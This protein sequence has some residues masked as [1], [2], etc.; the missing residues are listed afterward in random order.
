MP[1][2]TAT[3][4]PTI[5]ITELAAGAPDAPVLVVGPALGTTAPTIW[6]AAAGLLGD[7]FRV[8]GWDLPGH[9]AGVPAT[10][11]SIAELAAGVRAGVDRAAGAA[12]VF[13]YAGVSVSGVVGQQLLLDAPQ[14]LHSAVLLC[15]GARIGDRAGWQERAAGI[16]DTGTAVMVDALPERW[17][18]PEFMAAQP[19][20]VKQIGADVAAADDASYAALCEA[21]GEFDAR[22]RLAEITIPVLC[23]AGE[24]DPGTTVPMLRH[25][26]DGVVN[27]RL[28][29]LPGVSHL[30]PAQ[31][32]EDVARLI[33]EHTVTV[34]PASQTAVEA[35]A[36]GM[37][38]RREVLGDEYVN[39]VVPSA[40]GAVI[41]DLIARHAW[42]DVWARPGLDRKTRSVISIVALVSRGH[43]EELA[44]HLQGARNNGWTDE[45][46]A[47]VLLQCAIY[48]GVPEAN[49]AFRVARKA[50]DWA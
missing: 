13:H 48:C 24:L 8:L 18:T 43:H 4:T 2:S 42:N 27:G 21:L 16:R 9:G 3:A 20:L 47:E 31:A 29:V 11:F 38:I 15:T 6:G 44:L 49:S 12:T 45:E 5:A 41:Q 23:I 7:R 17:F 28:A 26:A 46:I 30:A 25:I 1:Q 35:H 22:A 19:D 33:A 14:R 37:R 50:L 40:A 34:P 32:P 36:I 39:G 10:G